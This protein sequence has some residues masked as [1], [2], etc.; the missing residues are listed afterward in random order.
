[1]DPFLSFDLPV[2]NRYLRLPVRNAGPLY[3]VQLLRNEQMVRE[4]TIEL[5]PG[6]PVDWWAFYDLRDF[7]GETLRLEISAY[8]PHGSPP[9]EPP[10]PFSP[11]A[12][13]WLR[14]A[15]HLSNTALDAE[16][17]YHERLRPQ[18]HYTPRRG[19]NNDPNGLAYH[20]GEWHMFY[21]HNPFG[22]GWGNM[23]WGHAASRDLIHWVELDEALTQRSLADM[24]FSGGG[25]TDHANTA[26]FQR[27]SQPPLVVAFTST[28]RGECLAYSNDRGRTL[29]EWEGNPFLAHRGRD[30]KII[31]YPPQ[32][33]WVLIVYE[34]LGE[35]PD[36]ER[37]YAIYD[38]PDLKRWRRLDFLPGLWE[39][40]ELLHLPLDGNPGN[41][42]WVIYGARWEGPRSTC[43]IGD[44][45]GERFTQWEENQTAHYGP[46]FYAPQV[47]SDAP[48]GR[49][50]MLGWLSGAQ[51]PGMPFSQGMTVP[52]ELSLRSTPLGARLCFYPAR[53]LEAL[54]QG[55]ISGA[56]LSLGGAN[57]LLAGAGELL[58]VELVLRPDGPLAL[59]VRGHPV[60]YDPGAHAVGFAGSQAILP[61]GP[62][63]LRLRVLVDRAVTEVFADD[64]LAAFSAMTL[65]GDPGAPIQPLRLEGNGMV[66]QIQIHT[67]RP[68]WTAG[69]MPA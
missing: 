47:F 69:G 16:D 5:P 3:R 62:E 23:H 14:R 11:A 68:A 28:G 19:W 51:Y 42:R 59:D 67:L 21:Q 60:D 25:L 17:L 55:T 30:P 43:L 2:T 22:V 58:D 36:P 8:A 29:V 27:G 40:P 44:F 45:D 49:A 33:K 38:S 6:E 64:G 4:F 35:G 54:R 10:A 56:G 66:E 24:A 13:D 20:A 31:W 63:T 18:F 12:C 57:E 39:C 48:G 37:G 65:P 50:I 53:E 61:P 41:A 34:E 46:H 15:I 26:G 9:A 7:H 1:M 32:E 52:L